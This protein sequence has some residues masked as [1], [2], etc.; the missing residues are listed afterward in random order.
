MDSTHLQAQQS[1][2]ERVSVFGLGYVGCVTAACLAHLGHRVI[3]IDKDQLKVQ[4]I[5]NRR[6]PFYEPGLHDLVGWAVEADRLSATSSTAAAVAGSGICLVCVGTPSEQNGNQVL[7]QLRRVTAEIAE[8]ATGRSEPLIVAIRST[9]FPGVCET[10]VVPAFAGNP[11]VSVVSHPE[12]LREGFAVEDFLNPALIVV[13]GDDSPACE[14]V[15]RLYESI[16]ADVRRVSL[17]AAEMIKYT[18]NAFHSVKIAF[19]N[20]IGA[21]SSALGVSGAEVMKTLC[22][23]TRLNIS[24]AYLTP[25]FA[26]GGSCLPKDLR[27]LVHWSS[28]LDLRLPLLENVLPSNECHLERGLSAALDLGLCRLGV[29]GLAFK[30]N[31]DDLRES[32]AVALIEQLIAKGREIRI[33]DPHVQLKSI[34]GANRA[35]I[36]KA[37]PQMGCLLQPDV[38]SLLGWAEKLLI[39]RSPAPE[40]AEEILRSGL[41]LLDLTKSDAV[42]MT[43]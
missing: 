25:G 39:L 16:V 4:A 22:L 17:R 23:D 5:L 14:R 1:S 3:G 43:R 18:C 27:A 36:L 8:V 28:R 26:F 33:F 21:V 7:T 37:I 30:E 12:F 19:A 2:C 10:E 20:E 38:S 15:A 29:F 40:L 35:Y 41:P 9:V 24:P 32:P 11:V 31:T 34:H 42:G 6:A 13:G